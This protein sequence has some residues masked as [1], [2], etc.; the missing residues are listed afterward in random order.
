MTTYIVYAVRAGMSGLATVDV[1]RA[2]IELR[3]ER[4]AVAA[5]AWLQL[6]GK[7][8][9]GDDKKGV[10]PY[11]RT[12]LMDEMFS[13]YASQRPDVQR[14]FEGKIRYKSIRVKYT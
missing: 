3:G 8:E 10:L 6:M 5:Y 2:A 12:I 9:I 4:Q 7:T 1:P 13:R 14:T 11:T